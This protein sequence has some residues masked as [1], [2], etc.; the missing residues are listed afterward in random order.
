MTVK[1]ICFIN[2]Y[3]NEK[4]IRSCLD[5]VFKQIHPFDEVIIVDDGSS[6][7][8]I[9]IISEFSKIY[10]NFKVCRKIMRGNFL[11]LMQYCH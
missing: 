4:F 8:S 11:H 5:S 3:N 10:S 9:D 6:D 1:N 2:N 7:G